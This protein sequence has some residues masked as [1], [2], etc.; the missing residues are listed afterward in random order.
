MPPGVRPQLKQRLENYRTEI[1]RLKKE[2]VS[3]GGGRVTGRG[4]R[5]VWEGGGEGGGWG[6]GGRGEYTHT[7]THMHTLTHTHTH[8]HT[9]IHSQKQSQIALGG[10]GM[11]SELFGPEELHTSED[12]VCLCVYMYIHVPSEQ[13]PIT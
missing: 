6:G 7:H 10:A 1:K 2:F 11:R 13:E 3:V 4:G 9:H 12:Q 8:T 5:G